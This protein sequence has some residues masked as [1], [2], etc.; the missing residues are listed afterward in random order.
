MEHPTPREGRRDPYWVLG[1]DHGASRSDIARAYRRA[2]H[3]AHPDTRPHDP[4]AAGRF[5]ALTDAYDLLSDPARRADYDRHHPAELP[6]T[7]T[8]RPGLANLS[9]PPRG[10]LIWAGPV[11]IE[12]GADTQATRQHPASPPVAGFEDPPVILGMGPMQGWSWLW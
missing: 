10:R 3:D 8:R 2:V 12:P 1:V 9:S 6:D 11:R 7:I 5:Q 4:Q